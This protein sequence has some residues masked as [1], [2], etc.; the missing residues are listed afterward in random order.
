[1]YIHNHTHMLT[2]TQ[3]VF[4]WKYSTQAGGW[5]DLSINPTDQCNSGFTWSCIWSLYY[6]F[7]SLLLCS[8]LLLPTSGHWSKCL[9]LPLPVYRLDWTSS[10]DV[11]LRL[12]ALG[13]RQCGITWPT[14]PP[15]VEHG[16]SGPSLKAHASDCLSCTFSQISAGNKLPIRSLFLMSPWSDF[17]PR[18]HLLKQTQ[19]LQILNKINKSNWKLWVIQV[20]SIN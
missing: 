1:M 19:R 14:Y 5:F 16:R 12:Q 18:Y 7:L 4:L 13:L 8:P 3:T 10:N 20:L 11:L 17:R 2:H 6:L 9:S 15:S